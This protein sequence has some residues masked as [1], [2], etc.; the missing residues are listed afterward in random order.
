MRHNTKSARLIPYA[1]MDSTELGFRA[2]RLE[3]SEKPRTRK[4]QKGGKRTFRVKNST[5]NEAKAYAMRKS[6]R[7]EGETW[8]EWK[9]RTGYRAIANHFGVSIPAVFY[10]VRRY[11]A[12][13]VGGH[14]PKE[15]VKSPK[16]R[17]NRS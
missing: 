7:E 13:L 10:A 8:H 4:L 14:R 15:I 1:G 12:D 3:R 6:P 17:V 5:V 11:R 9:G 2:F 16:N